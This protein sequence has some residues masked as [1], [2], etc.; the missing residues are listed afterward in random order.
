MA[1]K[2]TKIEL[3]EEE[4]KVL[5]SWVRAGKTDNSGMCKGENDQGGSREI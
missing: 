4:K 5:L 3:T 1:R 2:F